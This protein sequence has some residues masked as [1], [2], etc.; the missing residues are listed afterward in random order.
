MLDDRAPEATI[1]PLIRVQM[2]APHESDPYHAMF[3]NVR[4]GGWIA[5]QKAYRLGR[6]PKPRHWR[7]AGRTAERWRKTVEKYPQRKGWV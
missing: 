1:R 7:K 2:E 3:L 5:W 4:V 6:S